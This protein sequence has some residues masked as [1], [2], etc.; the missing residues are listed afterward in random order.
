MIFNG[1]YDNKNCSE[2]FQLLWLNGREEYIFHISHLLTMYA[3]FSDIGYLNNNIISHRF[4][5]K[6][7]V[8]II[9]LKIQKSW[10]SLPNF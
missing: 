2:E 8:I 1:F 10:N 5:N 6:Q 9:F 3:I 4:M 7:F